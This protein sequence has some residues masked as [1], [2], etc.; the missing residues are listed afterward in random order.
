M[1]DA[2]TYFIDHPHK[3]LQR[4]TPGTALMHTWECQLCDSSDEACRNFSA[5]LREQHVTDQAGNILPIPD[6][7]D[8]YNSGVVGL[9][10]SDLPLVDETLHLYDQMQRISGLR[11]CEQ[12]AFGYVLDRKTRLKLAWDVVYHYHTWALRYK[13]EG[14]LP[15]FLAEAADLPQNVSLGWLYSKRP[16]ARFRWRVRIRI[17]HALRRLGFKRGIVIT[18]ESW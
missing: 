9:H 2:D 18:S 5:K 1:L 12:L 6:Q 4:L 3:L 17:Q 14:D 8:S 11:T 15:S 13:F 10:P 7:F 16:R